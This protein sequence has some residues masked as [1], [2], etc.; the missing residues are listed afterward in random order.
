MSIYHGKL[1]GMCG[2]YNQDVSDDFID[3]STDKSLYSQKNLLDFARKNIV[4]ASTCT[5]IDHDDAI[6]DN[7]DQDHTDITTDGQSFII[8]HRVVA[9]I[10]I[11][12]CVH[13]L[14]C[15]IVYTAFLI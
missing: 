15:Y 9:G 5:Q 7:F 6:E 11:L 10:I 12:W 13:C 1:R 3:R 14:H 4:D 2:N 8:Q